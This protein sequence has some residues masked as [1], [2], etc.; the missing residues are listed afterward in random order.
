MQTMHL[1]NMMVPYGIYGVI[2]VWVAHVSY[3][4]PGSKFFGLKKQMPML[5]LIIEDGEVLDRL[6]GRFKLGCAS[7]DTILNQNLY[8]YEVRKALLEARQ[9][10]NNNNPTT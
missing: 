2:Y 1:F 9:T 6:E 3:A 7:E 4:S 5:G 8:I 10:N